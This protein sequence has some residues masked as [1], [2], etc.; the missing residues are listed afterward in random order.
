VVGEFVPVDFC[1]RV[2][3]LYS[4]IVLCDEDDDLCDDGIADAK[5]WGCEENGAHKQNRNLDWFDIW[6]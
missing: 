5:R 2:H 3:T 4:A 6:F 1:A